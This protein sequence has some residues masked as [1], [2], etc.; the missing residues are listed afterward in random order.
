MVMGLSLTII[1]GFKLACHRRSTRRI[2][3]VDMEMKAEPD[4]Q[5]HYT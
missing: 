5:E 3:I 1:L 2:D 4:R